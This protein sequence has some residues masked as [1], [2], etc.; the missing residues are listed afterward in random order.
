LRQ[1]DLNSIPKDH[2]IPTCSAV[3]KS[4]AM[5]RRL[6]TYRHRGRINPDELEAV[7]YDEPEDPMPD[8]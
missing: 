3:K 1:Q 2:V 6:N 7:S 8:V 4:N 5:K